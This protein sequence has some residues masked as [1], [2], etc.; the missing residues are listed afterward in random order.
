LQTSPADDEQSPQTGVR[1]R[2]KHQRRTLGE[3]AEDDGMTPAQVRRLV[4]G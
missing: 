4:N 2:S 3:K 1:E